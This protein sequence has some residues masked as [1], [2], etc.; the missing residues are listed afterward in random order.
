LSTSRPWQGKLV[1]T[2][3]V[4]SLE[5]ESFLQKVIGFLSLKKR[6]ISWYELPKYVNFPVTDYWEDAGYQNATTEWV[7]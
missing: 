5:N 1:R 7:E 3:Y 4:V 6:E 2:D